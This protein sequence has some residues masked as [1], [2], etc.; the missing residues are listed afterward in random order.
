MDEAYCWVSGWG[1]SLYE[2][3]GAEEGLVAFGLWVGCPHRV[4]NLWY[5]GGEGHPSSKDRGEGSV[6]EWVS[7][8]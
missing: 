2:E 8:K 1:L 6:W 7:S 5:A 4:Y 3:Q